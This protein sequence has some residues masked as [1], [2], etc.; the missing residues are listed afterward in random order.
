MRRMER[1]E[2]GSRVLL[3]AALVPS[4]HFH[5]AAENDHESRGCG[6]E[7]DADRR[8]VGRSSAFHRILLHSV[9]QFHGL[10]SSSSVVRPSRRGG[11]AGDRGDKFARRD[12]RGGGGAEKVVT[13]QGGVLLAPALKLLDHVVQ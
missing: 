13:V 6:N 4:V 11:V 5:F 9:C 7:D 12:V 2:G 8:R 3:S 10:E 1:P